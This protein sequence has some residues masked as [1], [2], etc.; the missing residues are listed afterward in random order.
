M[1]LMGVMVPLSHMLCELKEDTCSAHAN[2]QH[3]SFHVRAQMGESQSLEMGK[4][5]G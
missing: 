5:K 3:H 2:Y 4:N 1:S